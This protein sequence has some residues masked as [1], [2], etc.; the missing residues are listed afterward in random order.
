MH[1]SRVYTTTKLHTHA[2]ATE[3]HMDD[4][5][6]PS[7]AKWHIIEGSK[8]GGP[9]KNTCNKTNVTK[10]TYTQTLS[11]EWRLLLQ[12]YKGIRKDDLS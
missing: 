1:Q 2:I 7:V 12:V 3:P 11:A 8:T 5:S 6:N 4:S 10:T 9:S